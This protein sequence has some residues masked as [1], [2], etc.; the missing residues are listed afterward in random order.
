[1]TEP[2]PEVVVARLRPSA[3]ELI[4]PVAALVL[5]AGACGFL[6]GRFPET[7]QNLLAVLVAVVLA[8][9]LVG[10]PVLRWLAQ[11]TVVTTRRIVVRSGVVARTRR[12]LL[13]SR[14]YDAVLHQSALQRL[15]RSGDLVMATGMG[16]PVVLRDLPDAQLVQSALAE[17][18]DRAVSR[19]AWRQPGVGQN[20]VL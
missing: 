18:A 4:L 3:R 17:L 16:E 6:V 20:G 12:E 14:G 5:I 11:Q 10:V 13:H 9:V 2:E 7:W 19:S 8:V 1:M 15:F